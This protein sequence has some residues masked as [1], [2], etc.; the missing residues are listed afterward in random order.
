MYSEK[1]ISFVA[2]SH[3]GKIS[4]KELISEENCELSFGKVS[5]K[6]LISEKNCELSSAKMSRK[7]LISKQKCQF[8]HL[9]KSLQKN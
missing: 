5:W 9:A 1:I 6:A 3:S 8:S 2:L 4:P 7:A